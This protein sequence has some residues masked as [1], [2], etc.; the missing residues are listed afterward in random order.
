[1][2]SNR[3]RGI[4]GANL[5]PNEERL[6]RVDEAKRNVRETATYTPVLYGR[7]LSRI[8]C[9][10]FRR[11]ISDNT[12]Y[13]S[14]CNSL[15]DHNIAERDRHPDLVD[16]LALEAILPVNYNGE[17]NRVLRD[18]YIRC[19]TD[20]W[21]D[22]AVFNENHEWFQDAIQQARDYISSIIGRADGAL[23][24]IVLAGIETGFW[25]EKIEENALYLP[26]VEKMDR[27]QNL[28]QRDVI[29][30]VAVNGGQYPP[31]V[32][33]HLVVKQNS[34]MTNWG[35]DSAAHQSL[36]EDEEFHENRAT[37][38]VYAET[39][40]NLDSFANAMEDKQ[41][42]L[43]I[44]KQIR[45]M[46][47]AMEN[48]AGILHHTRGG[49]VTKAGARGNGGRPQSH[50]GSVASASAFASSGIFVRQ[51]IEDNG[52]NDGRGQGGLQRVGGRAASG[53]KEGYGGGYVKRE[54]RGPSAN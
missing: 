8:E 45:E 6:R 3:E 42:A 29:T 24:E 21:V 1:M 5:I 34:D 36:Y 48:D 19:D 20:A 51:S 18:L 13:H 9:N 28:T 32:Y 26:V 50:R 53:G 54:A 17:Y 7:I 37:S 39:M 30:A 52:G 16:F 40:A 25:R 4:R 15:K 27:G 11:C 44:R 38:T 49:R 47:E 14:I 23:L 41:K 31:A 35:N 33:R 12:I 2:A 43:E 22:Q 10:T 46:K